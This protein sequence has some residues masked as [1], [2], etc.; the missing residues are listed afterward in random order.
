MNC[1]KKILNR[2]SFNKLKL[3]LAG[4]QAVKFIT[5]HNFA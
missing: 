4:K 5:T 2:K 3:K 1:K